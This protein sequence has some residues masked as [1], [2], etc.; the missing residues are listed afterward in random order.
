MSDF[1]TDNPFAAPV[2]DLG[3]ASAAYRESPELSA[4]PPAA[5][6]TRLAAFTLDGLALILI[7]L[8]AGVAVAIDDVFINTK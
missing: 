4:L 1:E 8:A 2:A 3:P 5:N 6:L 7:Y